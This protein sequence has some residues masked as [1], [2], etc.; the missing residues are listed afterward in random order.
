[1]GPSDRL[2][3]ARQDARREAVPLVLL[4][5]A[6]LLALAGASRLRDWELLGARDWW[7]W[8][9]V[10]AP[11]IALGAHLLAGIGGLGG[12]SGRAV[13]RRLLIAVG[14]G[15]IV[16]LAVLLASLVSGVGGQLPGGQLLASAFVVVVTNILTFALAFW[17]LDG[18]GPVARALADVRATPDFQF[19][20]DENPGLA[21]PGWEPRLPD[22]LYVALTNATAFSPT[23]V[24]PLSR[25]AKLL[26]ALEATTS[27]MTLIVV[28]AR[29]VNVLR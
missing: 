1:M 27:F 20:Q 17:Q 29:A 6:L 2:T 10:V 22:Y 7:L 24:M 23:D 3:E 9:V 25:R 15:N 28:A 19:P 4:D 5:A 8:L 14:A 21:E 13:S 18:G 16:G 11:L 26:M 12:E